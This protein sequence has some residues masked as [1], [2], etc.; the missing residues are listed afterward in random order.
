MWDPQLSA[1]LDGSAPGHISYSNIQPVGERLK[2]WSNTFVAD[3]PVIGTRGPRT[4]GS[5]GDPGSAGGLTTDANSRTLRFFG[6]REEWSGHFAFND[7]H[8]EFERSLFD[9][10]RGLDQAWQRTYL[11]SRGPQRDHPFLDE[12]DDPKAAN[13][14]LGIFLKAGNVPSDFVPAWD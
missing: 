13:D 2:R 5:G 11:G 1:V 10:H 7:N 12:P 3:E 9:V 6:G 4:T 8:V 14:F